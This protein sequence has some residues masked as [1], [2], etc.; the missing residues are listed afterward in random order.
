M[1]GRREF[2]KERLSSAR[3]ATRAVDYLRQ[4]VLCEDAELQDVCTRLAAQGEACRASFWGMY[5]CHVL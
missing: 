4:A 3:S 5:H 2:I 1:G